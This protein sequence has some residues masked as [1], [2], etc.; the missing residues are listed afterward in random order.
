MRRQ[1]L[2]QLLFPGALILAVAWAIARADMDQ[3]RL[4]GI[5]RITFYAVLGTGLLLAWRFRRS[6][7][8]LCLVVLTIADQLLCRADIGGL[9]ADDQGELVR[10]LIGLL[11]PLNLLAVAWSRDRG[12]F[13][14][15]TLWRTGLLPAQ[16]PACAVV[17]V[18]PRRVGCAVLRRPFL[19][20][21]LPE[22]VVLSHAAVIAFGIALAVLTLKA[23]RRG[24]RMDTAVLWTVGASFTALVFARPP[25]LTTLYLAAGG[26]VL[27]ASAVEESFRM[28]YHDGL[29][30]LPG[31]RALDDALLRL[32]GRCAVA[33]V[34]VDRFKAI[35]DRHGHDAGDQVLRLVASRIARLGAGARGFRYGGDE[36]VILF[37][38]ATIRDASAHLQGLRRQIA[39]TS[40]QVRGRRRPVKRPAKTR[41]TRAKRPRVRIRLS[42]GVAE[43]TQ[44]S[45]TGED[46]LRAADAALY[47]AKRAGRNRVST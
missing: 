20:V 26:L 34:D 8:A 46:V 32:G 39:S 23:V 6:R 40:F 31:R 15:G 35:N 2:W 30:G 14:W 1:I 17:C 3:Q 19:P 5:I 47:R 41:T 29:T 13:T 11:L 21:S 10:S 7:L 28:A 4:A 36:F 33:M 37:P 24:D 44:R 38:G 16:V 45:R 22:E 43:R 18:G 27:V 12:L 25:P 42:I 9:T